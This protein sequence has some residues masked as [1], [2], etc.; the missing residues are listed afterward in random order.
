VVK[1]LLYGMFSRIDTIPECDWQT[2]G[3]ARKTKKN[4]SV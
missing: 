2:D 3:F 1:E 4:T